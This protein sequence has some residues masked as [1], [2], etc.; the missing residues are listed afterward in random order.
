M[1]ILPAIDIRYRRCVRL[2]QGDFERETVFSEDPI[3]MA[4]RWC[5]QGAGYL[6]VVDLDG[7]RQGQPANLDIAAAIALAVDIPVELGGGIRTAATVEAVL[8]AGIERA[9]IGTTAALD[10]ERAGEIFRRFGERV[11][12]GLDASNGFVATHGWQQVTNIRATELAQKLEQIGARR[13]IFTDISRDGMLEGINLAAMEEMVRAVSIPVI[14][15]GGVASLDDI[16]K[17]LPLEPL[18]LE[19]VIIGK[20]LYTGAVDLREAIAVAEG[21]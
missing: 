13:I 19:G 21:Q 18:G 1:L 3:A 14:A 2:V 5:E 9:I 10:I 15:S 17:L 8:G 11:V 20:A 4:R 16:R 7:A 6:H 12:L